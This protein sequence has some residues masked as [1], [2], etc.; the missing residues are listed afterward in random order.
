MRKEKESLEENVLS[1]EA[2]IALYWN[3]N[4][5]AITE[6]DRKYK[7]NKTNLLDDVECVV[8]YRHSEMTCCDAD[9]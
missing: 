5:Q 4:E 6:T 1:D 9:K 7:K 8:I 2:I 3:R